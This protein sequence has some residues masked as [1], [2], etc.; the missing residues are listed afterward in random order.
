MSFVARVSVLFAAVLVLVAAT[1]TLASRFDLP[2]WQVFLLD[3]LVGLPL[4]LWLLARFLRPATAVIRA[5]DDAFGSLGDQDYSVRLAPTRDDELGALVERYNAIA[6]ALRDQ[7]VDLR[8]RE[9]L[10]ETALHHSP[11]AIVLVNPRGWVIYANP[12]ARRLFLG[13]E[14]LEGRGFADVLEG[15]PQ[16]MREVLAAGRDGLFTVDHEG[17]V[18]TYHLAQRTFH[19]NRRPHGLY[20]LRRMTPEIGRQEARIWKKVIRVISHELNNSLAPISSLAH[21]AA[22]AA[23]KPE[24]VHRLPQIFANIEERIAHLGRFLEGYARFAR[25]P[26]PQKQDVSW[27]EF[28]EPLRALH[29]FE[30]ENELPSDRAS[31]DPAQMEQVVINLVKNAREASADGVGVLVR[32]R[33]APDGGTYLQVVDHGA[34]MGD[35]VL[36]QALLPFYSTKKEGVGVGLALCREIVSEH[37]GTLRIESREGEGTVVSCWLPGVVG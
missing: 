14:K 35:D 28:L 34:G 15:C 24:H 9:L 18:E 8:Q 27:S 7:H 2:A 3:L 25:L 17:E 33:A 23:G 10:L 29:P 1:S 11:S 32:L 37:G 19:L 16:E 31:F 4:G 26:Q 5:L 20:L 13:G 36:R 6:E 21:S 30:I 22:T 12:E